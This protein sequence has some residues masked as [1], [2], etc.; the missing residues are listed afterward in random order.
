[1]LYCIVE[2]SDEIE[3][4]GAKAGVE[5]M[6]LQLAVAPVTAIQGERME[7]LVLTSASIPGIHAFMNRNRP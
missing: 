6:P 7:L 4:P 5:G 1:V 2:N 3:L